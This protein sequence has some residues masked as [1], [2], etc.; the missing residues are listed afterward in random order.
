MSLLAIRN[1]NAIARR[2]VSYRY[3]LLFVFDRVCF[4]IIIDKNILFLN[5]HSQVLC[6]K[7]DGGSGVGKVFKEKQLLICFAPNM[8]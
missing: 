5:T 3:V 4:E 2:T 8:H 7:G 1:L 6:S